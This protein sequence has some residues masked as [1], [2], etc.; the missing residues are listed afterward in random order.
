M[1]THSGN[2]SGVLYGAGG[3]ARRGVVRA[4]RQLV[5]VSKILVALNDR[6]NCSTSTRKA[7]WR[8]AAGKNCELKGSGKVFLLFFLCATVVARPPFAPPLP[9]RKIYFLVRLGGNSG[10]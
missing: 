9:A 1:H 2:G 3:G 4:R 5:K 7:E 8:K 6:R 10:C